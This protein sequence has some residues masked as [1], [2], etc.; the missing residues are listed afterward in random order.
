MNRSKWKGPYSIP[1]KLKQEKVNKKIWLRSCTIL[2]SIV[3][4]I[5]SVYNGNEFKRI[6]ITRG[7]VGFK[8]G[9]FSVTRK[10]RMKKKVNRTKSIRV[11]PKK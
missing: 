11:T 10:F 7:R 3:G 2:N 1:F 9:E 8:F 6:I 5:I 4:T